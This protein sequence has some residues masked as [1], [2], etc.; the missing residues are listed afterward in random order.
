MEG[1]GSNS[2]RNYRDRFGQQVQN[3][4]RHVWLNMMSQAQ[5]TLD[6]AE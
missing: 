5:L 1:T 2:R 3:E 4:I 6:E